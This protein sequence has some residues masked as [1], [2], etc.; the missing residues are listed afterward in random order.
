[1][2]EIARLNDKR[3]RYLY[4]I[5]FK[6][7]HA[8]AFYKSYDE[9]KKDINE[10]TVKSRIKNIK[11]EMFPDIFKQINEKSPNIHVIYFNS[12]IPIPKEK[13]KN[14]LEEILKDDLVKEKL[15][16]EQVV[17]IWYVQSGIKE[18]FKDG[19]DSYSICMVLQHGKSPEIIWEVSRDQTIE[20][21]TFFNAIEDKD[22]GLA[23]GCLGINGDRLISTTEQD[24]DLDNPEDYLYIGQTMNLD[25]KMK[26]DINLYD[27]NGK[28]ALYTASE[29]NYGRL[30]NILVN[31]IEELDINKGTLNRDFPIIGALKNSSTDMVKIFIKHEKINLNL[32]DYEGKT[33][34]HHF[35]ELGNVFLFKEIAYKLTLNQIEINAVDGNGDTPLHIAGRKGNSKLYSFLVEN[36]ADTQFKNKNGEV[37]TLL[38]EIE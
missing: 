7:L 24:I 30:A 13:I 37:P 19:K 29:T 4:T 1:L 8:A 6:Y 18:R 25:N 22:I 15:M 14:L 20:Q 23:L 16:P 31:I 9:E 27:S 35:A 26:F 38:K 17:R 21:K 12:D 11:K 32:A 5:E 10:D 36:G 28:T 34:L 33:F 2:R 3:N